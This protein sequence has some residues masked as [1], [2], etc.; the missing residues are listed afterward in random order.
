MKAIKSSLQAA[1]GDIDSGNILNI[2]KL[3]SNWKTVVGQP[4]AKVSY[5]THIYKGCLFIKSNSYA[6][7]DSLIYYRKN[8][9]DK[10][11]TVLKHHYIKDIKLSIDMN[12]FMNRPD[13]SSETDLLIRDDLVE[14]AEETVSDIESDELKESIKNAIMKS[15]QRGRLK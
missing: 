7:G 6:F 11:N 1:L 10:G 15:A 3:R 8:I 13:R 4:L 2:I 5:P 12:L 9:I 14:F